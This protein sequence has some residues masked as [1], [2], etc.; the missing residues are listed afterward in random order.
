MHLTRQR[1]VSMPLYLG[2]EASRWLAR[3]PLARGRMLLSKNPAGISASATAQEHAASI[4]KEQG[5]RTR[6][7]SNPGPLRSTKSRGSLD[8]G[9]AGQENQALV[10][11]ATRSAHRLAMSGACPD[12]LVHTKRGE[13]G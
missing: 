12:R 5:D 4:E 9:P 13:A 6:M 1:L 8:M 11:A 7:G 10:C 2:G 3:G